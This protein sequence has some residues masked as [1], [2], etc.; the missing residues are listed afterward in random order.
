M[1]E[2]ITFF[3]VS[4]GFGFFNLYLAQETDF[5]YFGKYNKEERIAWLSIF[6]VINYLLVTDYIKIINE[7]HSLLSVMVIGIKDVAI[8]FLSSFILPKIIDWIIYLIRKMFGKSRRTF[9]PPI[10]SF[11]KD[12][13]N[14]Y[15]YSFSFDGKLISAGK[16]KH[17][18]EE[19]QNDLSIVI[20]PTSTGEK[21]EYFDFLETMT[22]LAENGEVMMIEFTDYTNKVHFVK[23]RNS[24]L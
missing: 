9:L 16:I 1:K 7:N 24:S 3:I 18:T 6:T 22:K 19:R 12:I 21:I 13:E 17:S 10:N 23:I 20:T 4:G 11:F 2:M 14:Y 8:S 5:L 15:L